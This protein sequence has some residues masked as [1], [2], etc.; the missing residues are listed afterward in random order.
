MITPTELERRFVDF[1]KKC[2]NDYPQLHTVYCD[3][4]EQV[5]I[6]GI[7]NAVVKAKLPLAVKNA[8][9]G[10]IIDRIRA[11]ASLI[12][13]KRMLFVSSCKETYSAF[14]EALWDDKHVKTEK[15][16]DQRLDD[17]STNI[18][19]IDAT[20]YSFEPYINGLMRLRN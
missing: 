12:T 9:K 14:N 8:R 3:S 5:L 1:A 10:P 4:A 11:G 13:Q 19:N 2:V 18:D 20:E 16:V 7:R 15:S 6:N 17:G